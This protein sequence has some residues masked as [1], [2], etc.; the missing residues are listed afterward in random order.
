MLY[1]GKQKS[2]SAADMN[3]LR[4]VYLSLALDLDLSFQPVAAVLSV[5][6]GLRNGPQL[7]C[8]RTFLLRDLLELK[9]WRLFHINAYKVCLRL[10]RTAKTS[11]F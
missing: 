7:S 11:A 8:N 6:Q 1:V 9:M 10:K 2:T 5:P 4:I 3:M